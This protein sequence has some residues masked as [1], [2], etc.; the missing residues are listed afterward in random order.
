M[1]SL[2]TA[3]T[4]YAKAQIAREE[5]RKEWKS[6]TPEEEGS[7]DDPPRDPHRE[8][9]QA[10]DRN[11][12]RLMARFAADPELRKHMWCWMVD[13]SGKIQPKWA[14]EGRQPTPIELTTSVK[15][16]VT[17]LGKRLLKWLVLN[18]FQVTDSGSGFGGWDM[19]VPCN[20][21]DGPRLC[22]LAY[23]EFKDYIEAGLLSVSLKFWDWRF[24]N[25]GWDEWEEILKGN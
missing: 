4:L 7:S 15:G 1:I 13:F 25:F 20:L 18:D 8:K 19:G 14:E 17:D 3:K 21:E 12:E 2:H 24:K 16:D 11:I 22:D 5:I 10:A 23:V 6:T 9:L